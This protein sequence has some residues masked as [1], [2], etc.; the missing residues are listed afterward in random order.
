MP[1]RSVAS[2]SGLA[3]FKAWLSEHFPGRR[4][5]VTYTRDGDDY[6]CTLK[7][8]GVLLDQGRGP[9]QKAAATDAAARCH[10]QFAGNPA[11]LRDFLRTR[12]NSET[13]SKAASPATAKAFPNEESSGTKKSVA[14][15]SKKLEQLRA[16]VDVLEKSCKRLRKEMAELQGLG[17]A[18]QLEQLRAQLGAVQ[19][20]LKE[21][22][23]CVQSAQLASQERV[24]AKDHQEG[25][26]E[27]RVVTYQHLEQALERW[28]PPYATMAGPL[29]V[30]LLISKLIVVPTIELVG[31]LSQALEPDVQMQVRCVDKRWTVWNSKLREALLDPAGAALSDQDTL[32]LLVLDGVQGQDL[33]TWARPISLWAQGLALI[34]QFP[35]QRWPNNL[36]LLLIPQWERPLAC[37]GV[38]GLAA[39]PP[40]PFHEPAWFDQLNWG[41]FLENGWNHQLPEPRGTEE[42]LSQLLVQLGQA[43]ANERWQ[44]L[45]LNTWPDIYSQ[46]RQKEQP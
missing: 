19:G 6:I 32:H 5:N 22:A 34:P 13:S 1:I 23:R 11:A 9:S 42:R 3:G 35:G 20:E 12:E 45:I 10:R 43:K 38:A 18:D 26:P 17:L 46:A 2:K 31:A 7:F 16:D 4:L 30:S 37:R 41:D 15:Q 8:R 36:R 21:V 27:K 24:A 40:T 28:A 33:H 25:P 44:N 29:L 39:V 14:L